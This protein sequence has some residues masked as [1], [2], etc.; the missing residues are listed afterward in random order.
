MTSKT[1]QSSKREGFFR[2][3]ARWFGIG[4]SRPAPVIPKGID[5]NPTDTRP[6]PWGSPPP[7]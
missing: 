2:R 6:E 3:L 1:P 5:D 4:K 7:P